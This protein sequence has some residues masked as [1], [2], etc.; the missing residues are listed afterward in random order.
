MNIISWNVNGIR[1]VLSKNKL[2][3]KIDQDDDNNVLNEI[4]KDID[5]LCIQE[6]KCHYPIKLSNFPYDYHNLAIK[7]GY[8]GVAIYSKIEPLNVFYNFQELNLQEDYEN[9]GRIITLE[10]ETL[11]LINVYVPNSKLYLER[12]DQRCNKWECQIRSY[13]D[14]LQKNKN[15]IFCGDL[16]VVPTDIDIYDKYHKRF[17]GYTIEEQEEFKK[18]LSTLNMI[19]TFRYKNPD[20]K[21]YTWWSNMYNSRENNKGLRIDFFI[22]SKNL[23]DKVES[24]DILTDFFGSDHA[25]VILK[26]NSL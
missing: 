24:S 20:V 11:Y 21:K 13:I 3:D 2:G 16:N 1:S 22:V 12:L 6:T 26:M 10:F 4:S 18:L 25:P 19:D 23:I 9:E 5:I 8:S 15:V 17:P 14:K 7:K